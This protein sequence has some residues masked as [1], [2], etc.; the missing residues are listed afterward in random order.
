[1]MCRL[2]FA[3]TH[4]HAYTYMQLYICVCVWFCVWS[5][6]YKSLSEK[7]NECLLLFQ[8]FY[9]ALEKSVLLYHGYYNSYNGAS[10]NGR[11]ILS[12]KRFCYITCN[13]T[14]AFHILFSASSSSRS[15]FGFP[16]IPHCSSSSI[17]RPLVQKHPRFGTLSSICSKLS[18]IFSFFFCC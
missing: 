9:S 5:Q 14:I 6:Y 11:I 12:F 7:K 17:S 16:L 2:F 1:M 18:N 15:W 4:A 3:N 13:I 10:I 8:T